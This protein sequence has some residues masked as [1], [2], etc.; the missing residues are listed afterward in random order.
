M[1]RSRRFWGVHQDESGRAGSLGGGTVMDL[2]SHRATGSTTTTVASDLTRSSRQNFNIIQRPPKNFA[3]RITWIEQSYTNTLATVTTIDVEQNMTFYLS[4]L[5]DATAIS[6]LFDQYCIYSCVITF[7]NYSGTVSA[8]APVALYTALDFDNTLNIG[9]K[10]VLQNFASYN[11]AQLSPGTS[12]ERLVYPCLAP[13][14][15]NSVPLPVASLIGRQWVDASYK[16][17]PHYGLRVF[18]GPT[19]AGVQ[20]LLI[21]VSMVIGLRNTV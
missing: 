9:S 2:L 13:T 17:I 19:S 1:P 15:S 8:N 16:D 7:T 20:Q 21:S 3:G 5:S 11:M 6:N 14:A 18:V 10:T 4:N 12:L